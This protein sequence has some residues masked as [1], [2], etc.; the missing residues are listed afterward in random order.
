MFK[1]YIKIAYRDLKKQKIYSVIIEGCEEE[2]GCH[3]IP[4]D[5][6]ILYMV[7]LFQGCQK[8]TIGEKSEGFVSRNQGNS[9]NS[10]FG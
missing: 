6:F 2:A 1:N 4:I 7:C 5:D 3:F 8:V 10:R 9:F